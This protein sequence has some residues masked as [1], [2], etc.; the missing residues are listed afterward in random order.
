MICKDMRK[1]NCKNRPQQYAKNAFNI[2][3][4]S[5]CTNKSTNRQKNRQTIRRKTKSNFFKIALFLLSFNLIKT[6][7]VDSRSHSIL[8]QLISELDF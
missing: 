8:F 5:H 3:L 6:S 1:F 2:K 7:L 4:K